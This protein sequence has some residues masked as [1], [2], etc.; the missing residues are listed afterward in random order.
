M[1]ERIIAT[2]AKHKSLIICFPCQ[3]RTRNKLCMASYVLT[4]VVFG[5]TRHEICCVHVASVG[6]FKLTIYVVTTTT[7]RR[8]RR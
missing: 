1:T 5:V 8:R 7:D 2:T 3:I 6:G 4:F